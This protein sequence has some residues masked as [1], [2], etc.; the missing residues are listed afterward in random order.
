MQSLSCFSFPR[1]LCSVSSLPF[2]RGAEMRVR[3]RKA[4]SEIQP[5]KK[6]EEVWISKSRVHLGVTMATR[7]RKQTTVSE[8]NHSHEQTSDAYFHVSLQSQI[9]FTTCSFNNQLINFWKSETVE[10]RITWLWRFRTRGEPI[11][12]CLLITAQKN[13]GYQ[14]LYSMAQRADGLCHYVLIQ[15]WFS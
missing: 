8:R 1:R 14:T 10:S 2:V 6:K 9:Y 12:W 4:F 7:V 15:L 5:L 11:D 13:G 3:R